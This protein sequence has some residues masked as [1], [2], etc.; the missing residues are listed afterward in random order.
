MAIMVFLE[1]AMVTEALMKTS[2]MAL[3]EEAA[4]PEMVSVFH[5]TADPVVPVKRFLMEGT[6]GIMNGTVVLVEGLLAGIMGQEVRLEV[7]TVVVDHNFMATGTAV[8][9]DHL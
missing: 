9:V 7:V 8:V 1:G 3:R 4:I 2:Q 6:G 5:V